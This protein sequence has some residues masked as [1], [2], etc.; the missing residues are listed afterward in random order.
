M[1]QELRVRFFTLI[2][3]L[4]MHHV[5]KLKALPKFVSLWLK[6]LKMYEGFVKA[7]EV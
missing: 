2:A 4:F 6:L 7:G 3:K 5:H 1:V